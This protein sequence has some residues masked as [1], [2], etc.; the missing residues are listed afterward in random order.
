[1]DLGT[2]YCEV[3]PVRIGFDSDVSVV[4]DSYNILSFKILAFWKKGAA[5]TSVF[6][7][8]AGAGCS[9]Q[10]C[11]FLLCFH[12]VTMEKQQGPLFAF[13]V[14]TSVDFY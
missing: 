6:L 4:R 1:M 5:D 14:I 11:F 10:F 12:V 9:N 2:N 3:L 13:I 8:Y 7:C